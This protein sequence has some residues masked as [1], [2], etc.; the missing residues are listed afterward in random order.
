V[1]AL[2]HKSS[3]DDWDADQREAFLALL[4]ELAFRRLQM[5]PIESIFEDAVNDPAAA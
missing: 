1:V 3:V 5:T 2:H 4:F